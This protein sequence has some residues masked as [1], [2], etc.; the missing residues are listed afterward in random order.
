[1]KNKEYDWA[2]VGGGVVGIVLSE[3][4]T[5][6]GH[7]VVLIEKNEKLAGETT[8]DFH[9]WIHTGS[10]YTLIPDNLFT[11]KFLLGAIDDLLEYYGGFEGMNLIPTEKGLKIKEIQN[12]WFNEHYIHFKFRINKRKVTIP[13][14][15]GVARAVFLIDRIKEHDWLRRRAGVTDPFKLKLSKIYPIFKTLLGYKEKFFDYRTTDF[16]TN[17]RNLLNDL[18]LYAIKN[19]LVVS[20]SNEFLGYEKSGDNYIVNASKES[21]VVKNIVFSNGANVSK[22]VDSTVKTSYAPMAVI[23]NIKMN[24][25]SFVELDYYPKNCINQLYKGNGIGLIGGISFNNIDECEKYI[26]Q[27]I[28][29]HKQY[30]PDLELVHKYIGKK[31]EIIL[32]NQPRNYLYH[33][34]EIDNNVWGI[35]PGKFT[36]AFSIAPEF[37]RRVF[38]KNPKK[39]INPDNSNP[40]IS[41]LMSNTM[42]YDVTKNK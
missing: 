37:Y 30:N 17:S 9:E 32:N 27:V 15:I 8:R 31:S 4:L 25:P 14:L 22:F 40:E 6:E 35:I 3:I 7:S 26:D 41:D 16:T 28:E 5:R 23:K 38:K 21:F 42:W 29:K 20:A 33:I 19:K 39:R 34:L 13:W 36:L 12:K 1:M 11:L 18:L 2:I 10:L 24:S